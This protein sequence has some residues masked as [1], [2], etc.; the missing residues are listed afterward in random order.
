MMSERDNRA[1]SYRNRNRNPKITKVLNE[2]ETVL[3]FAFVG[4]GIIVTLCNPASWWIGM[5]AILA[6]PYL[7][8][9]F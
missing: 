8:R 5:L 7:N 9:K 2:I 6:G 4:L 3:L 1:K